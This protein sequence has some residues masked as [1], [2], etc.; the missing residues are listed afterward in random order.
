MPPDHNQQHSRRPHYH[1]GR[2][3]P[4]RRGGER[5]PPQSQQPEP[6]NRD[7][8]DVEQIMR[9][10]RSR[11]S[12]RHG[13]DLTPQ[14]IQ[15]LA[16]RRLEAILDPRTIK[17]TLMDELRRA[18]GL[19]AD[20]ASPEPEGDEAITESALY[21]SDSGLMRG[22][23]KLLNPLLK[24]FFNPAAIIEALNAQTRR[25]KAAQARE[26]E[27]RR[28]Q[29]EWNA[30]H[31][32]ILRRLVTDVARVEI[33]NQH[34][35]HRVESLTARVDFNERRVRGLEHTQQQTRPSSGRV[36]DT[37]V[38]SSPSS[39]PSSPPSSPP[40]PRE[41]TPSTT[42]HASSDTSPEGNRRRRRRRRGRRSGQLRDVSGV[43][44]PSA[45]NPAIVDQSPEGD[46]FE[47]DATTEELIDEVSAAS[48][49]ADEATVEDFFPPRPPLESSS[50]AASFQTGSPSPNPGE[51]PSDPEESLQVVSS[52]VEQVP[53][54]PD[55]SP[56]SPV[57]SVERPEPVPPERS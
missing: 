14:Q 7:Q 6:A 15:E 31:F 9:E 48:T 16:A 41:E 53:S 1:R 47:D 29:T 42:E 37:A 18:A 11:I 12:E 51:A 57:D 56:A 32:D 20:T 4:D 2:R 52:P 8:L 5:R 26:A 44:T 46:E 3:G 27:L 50:P 54:A 23:R 40:S 21:Q 10:I 38:A 22:I 36:P 49:A 39:S 13:I 17:P 19:P 35:A 34:L 45:A 43:P 33:D 55:A 25:A 28:R 24:L 30:L